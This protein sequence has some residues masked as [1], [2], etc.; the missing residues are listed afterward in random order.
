VAHEPPDEDEVYERALK[1]WERTRELEK[2]R[3]NQSLEFSHG[4]VALVSVADLHLGGSGVDYPRLF[5]EAELIASTPGMFLVLVGDLVDSFIVGRLVQHRLGT[6]LNI[7]DEWALLRRYLRIV[8]LKVR[9]SIGGN[10]DYW[11]TMLSGIDYL[12]E[13]L[14]RVA[15]DAIYDQDDA[16]ITVKV[17][18]AEWPGRIRHKWA[19][20][21]IYNETH[22]PE[23]A[24]KWD[25][26]FV[27]SIGAHTHRGGVARSFNHAGRSG[28][29]MMCGSYK[30]VDKFARQQGF[31]KPNNS[32]AVALVFDEETG[33]MTGFDNLQMCAKFMRE[34]YGGG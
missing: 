2:R 16:R 8:G 34:L 12:R 1:E 21:S 27:W 22:G 33:S 24:A 28:W 20:N 29:A 4:P 5:A 26:D 31:P 7:T 11:H 3:A 30:R 23:R 32:A 19:G 15:P 18:S 17:G 10:H 6:R 13:V 9:A 25:Q 14:A